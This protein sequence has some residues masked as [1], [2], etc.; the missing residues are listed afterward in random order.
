SGET[1]T[2]IAK[3]FGTT[4]DQLS[5][6]NGGLAASDLQAGQ[7]IKV[8]ADNLTPSK[9]DRIPTTDR[10]S[11]QHALT[12]RVKR[13]DTLSTIADKFGVAVA[14]LKHANHLHRTLLTAGLRLRIPH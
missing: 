12:Y 5:K 6:W 9:G 3:N 1:M 4:T 10:S 14:A 8:Y 11:H 7:K 2:G 13:G